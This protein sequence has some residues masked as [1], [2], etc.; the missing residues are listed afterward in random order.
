MLDVAPVD[1]YPPTINS[2]PE[3]VDIIVNAA[4][5]IVGSNASLPQKTMGAEDFSLFLQQR[6]GCFYFVGAGLKDDPR[7][8][9]KSV[10]DFDEVHS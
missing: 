9:H 7:P 8:H 10:F 3:H 2:Y 1:G 5:K 4:A 6:P